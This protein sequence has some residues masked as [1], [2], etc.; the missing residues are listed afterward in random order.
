MGQGSRQLA[1]LYEAKPLPPPSAGNLLLILQNPGG[2]LRTLGSQALQTLLSLGF[3][4]LLLN[5]QG[6][7]KGP[8][9]QATAQSRSLECF[10]KS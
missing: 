10:F 2:L 8:L 4:R 3:Y 7:G 9:P 6:E 5:P 1:V